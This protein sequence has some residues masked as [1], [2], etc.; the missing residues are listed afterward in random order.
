MFYWM[1]NSLVS[2]FFLFWVSENIIKWKQNNNNDIIFVGIPIW[3]I[4]FSVFSSWHAIE[5]NTYLQVDAIDEEY[6]YTF[7]FLVIYMH[8]WFD[9]QLTSH[10][11]HNISSF[12]RIHSYIRYYLEAILVNRQII[13]LISLPAFYNQSSF[14]SFLF[15]LVVS[16]TWK[17]K[18][19]FLITFSSIN[20]A[21]LN[22]CIWQRKRW[23]LHK[24]WKKEEI[25]T[26][27]KQ[28]HKT[29]KRVENRKN[30]GLKWM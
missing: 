16:R 22:V 14:S 4:Y 7:S 1:R 21:T 5:G 3:I 11:V 15:F 26:R 30:T 29:E 2:D 13:C 23:A 27:I 12:K 17:Y 6:L 9:E 28:S 24:K 18:F 10:R 20:F 19:C 8:M 25:M